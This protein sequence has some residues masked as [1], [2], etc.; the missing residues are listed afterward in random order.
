MSASRDTNA[1]DSIATQFKTL[2]RQ[3]WQRCESA[4]MG[5]IGEKNAKTPLLMECEPYTKRAVERK[6]PQGDDKTR[7]CITDAEDTWNTANDTIHNVLSVALR[8]CAAARTILGKYVAGLPEQ[9]KAGVERD[10]TAEAK[11][12]FY[13]NGQAAWTELRET[14][15]GGRGIESAEGYL[16]ELYRLPDVINDVDNLLIEHDSLVQKIGQVPDMTLS[17]VF[18]MHLLRCLKPFPECDIVE[19]SCAID[20][21]KSYEDTVREVKARL[22]RLKAGSTETGAAF[23][24]DQSDIECW[25][26]GQKG[27][28]KADCRVNT[29]GRKAGKG[30]KGSR[31]G[32]GN[33]TQGNEGTSNKPGKGKSK[34]AQVRKKLK[35]AE[36]KLAEAESKN[37]AEDNDASGFGF[38]CEQVDERGFW[39]TGMLTWLFQTLMA[40]IGIENDACTSESRIMTLMTAVFA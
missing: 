21:T 38:S 20:Q 39:S 19:H 23:Y 31:S 14:A 22:N 34:G 13:A 7:A 33:Y 9:L 8:N 16:Q 6:Q 25:N 30:G 28:R 5:M 26:C 4:L 1:R 10:P 27:H 17:A 11:V 35:E 3:T 37:E 2:D 40:C 12:T 15:M 32:K 24:S 36:A 29:G 18:K